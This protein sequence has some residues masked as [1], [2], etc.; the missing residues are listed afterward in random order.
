MLGITKQDQEVVRVIEISSTHNGDITRRIGYTRNG[1]EWLVY[2]QE[3]YRDNVMD[4]KVKWRM[5]FSKVFQTIEEARTAFCGR[6]MALG[7][8]EG[9]VEFPEPVLAYR[10]NGGK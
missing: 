5:P 10:I 1:K 6:I 7:Y 8:E 2:E 9:N 3:A 4:D